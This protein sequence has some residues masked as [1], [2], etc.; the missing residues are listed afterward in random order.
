[1]H[2]ENS[3]L[4]QKTK[5]TPFSFSDSSWL[6]RGRRKDLRRRNKRTNINPIE[7]VIKHALIHR[8]TK[9]NRK[10]DV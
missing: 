1:M 9:T 8:K 10:A 5:I 6:G 4:Q 3:K 2:E 7:I